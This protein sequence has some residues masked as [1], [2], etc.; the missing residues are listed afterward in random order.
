MRRRFPTQGKPPT[1]NDVAVLAGVSS[2]TVSKFFSSRDYYIAPA[3][4]ERIRVAVEELQYRPSQAARQLV[5]QRSG[6][7]GLLIPDITNPYY[8]ELIA[9]AGEVFRGTDYSI[10]LSATEEDRKLEREAIKTFLELR[11][12]G[13]LL[14][15]VPEDDDLIADLASNGIQV[16][17]AG[18]N[19]HQ[20]M[21]DAV[22]PSD[23]AGASATTRHLLDHEPRSIVHLA[24]PISLMP[25]RARAE[26][27]LAEVSRTAFEHQRTITADR[28]TRANALA[29]CRT[30]RE[31]ITAGTAVFAGNDLMA[32]GVLDFCA[33]EGLIVGH[34]VLLAGF[35]NM[36]VGGI[37][38]VD[39]TSA[40]GQ[41]RAT[42]R[43]A[44]NL[45]LERVLGARNGETGPDPRQIVLESPVVIRKSCGC[46]LEPP[47]GAN[48]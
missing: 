16:V 36:P 24:G 44:A 21:I 25:F 13:V 33:E 42:G 48:K 4:R 28:A 38:G 23:L 18:R 15:V 9:G 6:I 1:I 40:D 8:P 46:K 12:E 26:G 37:P 7:I 43:T 29:T 34:D 10:Q 2:A 35:D 27:F 17:Y 31:L 45:L 47:R 30:N 20:T 11:V 19:S 5:R 32:L 14:C 39:L 22:V 41:I 3:T